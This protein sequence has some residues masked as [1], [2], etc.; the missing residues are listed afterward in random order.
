MERHPRQ[1]PYR[2]RTLIAGA[3]G[4]AFRLSS[5]QDTLLSIA[6]EE[7][8]MSLVDWLGS[9]TA[10]S[11]TCSSDRSHRR[12]PA[13]MTSSGTGCRRRRATDR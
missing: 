2:G 11:V 4:P 8:P 6:L 7:E 13:S 5:R 3:A 10:R 1:A 9:S 12:L